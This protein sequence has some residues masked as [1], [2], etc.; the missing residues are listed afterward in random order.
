MDSLFSNTVTLMICAGALLY[1]LIMQYFYKLYKRRYLL[2]WAGSWYAMVVF[3]L[4]GLIVLSIFGDLSTSHPLR[5]FISFINVSASYVQIALLL[6][7]SYELATNRSV[8]SAL[9]RRILLFLLILGLGLTLAYAFDPQASS[10]RYALRVGVKSMLTGISFLAGALGLIHIYRRRRGLGLLLV[11]VGF[12][13]YGVNQILQALP[14]LYNLLGDSSLLDFVPVFFQLDLLFISI[15]GLGLVIWLLEEEREKVAIA[16]RSLETKN[17]E[18]AQK[19]AELERFTYTVSHDLKSPLVTIKGFLGMLGQDIQDGDNENIKADI[20]HISTATDKMGQLLGE[21][22]ELSRIGRVVNPSEN[23]PL[24]ELAQEAVDMLAGAITAHQVTVTIEPDMPAVT[25]DRVRLLEV[26]QN[27]VENAVKFMNAQ[28]TPRIEIGAHK[29]EGNVVCYVRDNG[30]GIE[31][32]YHEQVFGIFNRLD[33]HSNGTGI[34]LALVKRIVEVHGGRIWV[35]S[36]GE[37]Q[38]STFYFTLPEV[39]EA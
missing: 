22:L 11:G 4:G 8:S 26:Y 30:I 39:K 28:P 5:L 7:G 32:K 15:I 20:Q 16:T 6:I 21:L 29:E 17:K 31:P 27:L 12:L 13:V 35:E 9:L 24:A 3:R 10:Q 19:N 33:A 37:G 14:S 34:G 23:I 38:G 25:G 2:F 36:P 18:L 1:A